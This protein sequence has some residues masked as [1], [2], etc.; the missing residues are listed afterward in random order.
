[1]ESSLDVVLKYQKTKKMKFNGHYIAVEPVDAFGFC[2]VC[3][4]LY[5]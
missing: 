3:P 2:V 1:M 4:T 5:M